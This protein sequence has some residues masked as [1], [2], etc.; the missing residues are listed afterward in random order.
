[1]I[2]EITAEERCEMD[3][4]EYLEFIESKGIKLE[5]VWVSIK[6]RDGSITIKQDEL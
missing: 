2:I 1:M 3:T 4:W 6:N 5:N